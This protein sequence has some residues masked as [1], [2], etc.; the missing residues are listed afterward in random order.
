MTNSLIK[1]H[2]MIQ[3]LFFLFP[4]I[5]HTLSLTKPRL[6][7]DEFFDYASFP[8]IS[9][10]PNGHYLIFHTRRASWNSSS[11]N[12]SLWLYDIQTNRKTLITDRLSEGMKPKWSP[13][14]SWIAFL[15]NEPTTNNNVSLNSKLKMEH[16]IYIY[17]IESQQLV[18]IP[19]GKQLPLVLTWANDDSSLYIAT[20]GSS[21]AKLYEDSDTDEWKDVIKYGK[22]KPSDGS[23]IYHVVLGEGNQQANTNII[24][25]K[26]LPFQISQLLFS[27]SE[28]KLVF[29][30]IKGL[31]TKMEDFEIYCMGARNASSFSRLTTNRAF[32]ENL[33]LSTD[34]KH[35]LFTLAGMGPTINDSIARQVTL[36][37][38]DL[39]TGEIQRLAKDF[40]GSITEYSIRPN[41]GVYILGQWRTSVQIYTQESA[42]KYTILHR[43]WEGTYQS[44]AS[45]INY[46]N[47]MIAFVHSS[48][49]QPREVYIVDNVNQLDTARAI[50][51]EN[52]FFTERTLAQTKIY[53]WTNDEDNRTIEGIL[54]Y[55]PGSM[56]SKN[57]PLLVLIHGGPYSASTNNFNNGAGLW[58][59]LAAT[60]GWLVLEPNY[61]GSTG[62]GDQFLEEIRYHP[63]SRPGKD[64]L[65]GINRLIEDGIVDR[66]RLAVGGHSY[67]GFLTNW[68]ITQTAQFNVALSGAGSVDQ[69]SMW[70]TMDIN[71]LIEH[72]WGG[73]PWNSP[74]LYVD[75]SPIYHFDKV[76]TATLIMFG[77]HDVRVPASQGYM[78]ERALHYLNVP[79]QLL[80]FPNEGHSMRNNPWHTKIMVREQL[81][82][83]QKYGHTNFLQTQLSK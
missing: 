52:K 48:H 19:V 14:G 62:Y 6:T 45:S 79:V 72:L 23:T 77:E 69:A 70:G 13:S 59:P 7:L 11:Y 43:G 47:N 68:L 17:C 29:T 18:S 83:L 31:P 76:R 81:K 22:F 64:I 82:W 25:L 49:S 65:S 15:L 33:S 9:L 66:N 10:S 67:G 51:D 39:R 27:S 32:E 75:E 44:I 12:N 50:T 73:F 28:Q 3:I 36:H 37:A 78:L 46:P 40:Q 38:V 21:S 30:S 5:C 8:S 35:A 80:I 61:R 74:N 60:E 57:F 58:G 41:G 63:L 56:E 24:V 71:L 1:I 2:K 26:T 55:P 4:L 16:H 54:H 53:Q 20:S 34:G 42:N